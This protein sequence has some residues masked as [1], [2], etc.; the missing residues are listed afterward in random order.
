MPRYS[1]L[2]GVLTVLFALGL[3]TGLMAGRGSAQATGVRA[4]QV[5]IG[6]VEALALDNSGN[7]W[8]WAAPKPQTFAT[9]FLLRIE[10][11]NWSIAADSASNATL[12]PLAT[13]ISKMV[14]TADGMDGWAIGSQEVGQNAYAPVL[15][16]LDH[17]IWRPARNTFSEDIE[18]NDLALSA[19][20]SVGWMI[21]SDRNTPG[22]KLL[23]LQN[24]N[25]DFTTGAASASLNRVAISAD[26]R[27]SWGVA[28][29]ANGDKA[30]FHWD[31][32]RWA[33]VP[34]AAMRGD[35][36]PDGLAVDNTGTG[37]I[38]AGPNRIGMSNST[39][40]RIT[41]Q[42]VKDMPFDVPALKQD[43]ELTLALHAVQVDG[44]GTGWAAGSIILDATEE[45][46]GTVYKYQPVFI[47]L[48]GDSATYMPLNSVGVAAASSIKPQTVGLTPDGA[49]GWFGGV[50]GVGFGTLST[51]PEPWAHARPAAGTPLPGAGRCFVEVPYCLRGVFARYWEDHGGL[52]QFGFPLTPEVRETLGGQAYL[53]QYTQR[54]RFEYHPENKAP[55]DVL[56]GLLGNTLADPRAREAA[57]KPASAA[58]GAGTQWFPATQHNV[59][60]PF[61]TYWQANGGVP[62]FGLPRSEAF[63]ERNA[64]DG[65]TYKVQYFE[66]NRLEYHPENAGTRFAMLRGL[67]GVEQFTK[68]FGYTP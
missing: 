11:G 64:A 15:W 7:G 59:G 17:G 19:D 20:G 26:G 42:G 45:P 40:T 27:Q 33:V 41:P 65:K 56:L 52:E 29:D 13:T 51:L 21:V 6:P 58:S 43:Q 44:R 35:Q 24:G 66:R 34:G 2:R 10:N 4:A 57:F 31:G 5:D 3:L 39:L 32:T 54:A 22:H 1:H 49:H 48:R 14:I 50:T 28:T 67:L 37:W 60:A 68:T 36:F 46:G 9:S 47:R 55:Y 63:D 12:L 18:L 23:R 8:A 62:V 30:A 25:W 61:L 53:V 38:V 16:R